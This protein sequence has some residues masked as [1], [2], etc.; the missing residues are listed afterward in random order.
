MSFQA[1]SKEAELHVVMYHYVRDLPGTR[2]PKIKGMMLNEF[3]RQIAWLASH[4]E[5]ATL[6]AALAFLRGAYRPSK[7]LCIFTFDDGLKEHYT[8]VAPIL[9]EYKIQGLFGVITSCIEDHIVAPVHM[10]HFLM[11]DMGFEAY[12]SAFLQQ[13]S[14]VEP[15]ALSSAYVDSK[16][17]QK[18]YP[19]DTPEIATFKFLFNFTLD[20]T[21]RDSIVKNLFEAYLGDQKDFAQ[22]LY[23]SWD[24]IRQ[25]QRAGMLVA[26]HTHWHRPLS[27]LTNEEL[28]TDLCISRTLLDQNL[29]PQQLWPFS[30][31]YGKKNSYSSRA[32][33]LLQQLGY[34]C[35]FNTEDGANA[36]GTPM[37]EV[38]RIDCKGAI[39]Q[40]QA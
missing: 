18:S 25:L 10:N 36:P 26:G 2:Y 23:M 17:A 16:V 13:L 35:A 4:Y 19:L 12:R 31:P 24:E 38:N 22:E 9:S 3:R 27:T 37:F 5:M 21:V 11:A 40:L 6:E 1:I 14:D 8:D 29:D 34:A 28:D 15:G 39:R 30:Y 7:D 33:G 20:A 32:I